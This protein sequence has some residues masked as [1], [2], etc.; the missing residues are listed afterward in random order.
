MVNKKNVIQHQV[1]LIFGASKWKH[2]FLIDFLKPYSRVVF[3][4]TRDAYPLSPLEKSIKVLVWAAKYSSD[5]KEHVKSLNYPVY[6]LEDGFLRSVGLGINHA[7]PL[8]LVIDSRGM[9]YD[10]SKESDLEHILN[11]EEFDSPALERAEQ[12]IKQ[13]VVLKLTKYNLKGNEN[14]S[15]QAWLDF[16][17]VAKAQ[18]KRVVLVP[19]QVDSDA[20][21]EKGSPQTKTNLALLQAVATKYP[22]AFIVYKPHPDVLTQLRPGN[23][24]QAKSL[25]DLQVTNVDMADLLEV[26]DEV[27]TMTSLTGFEAL[28]RHKKVVC[29]GLPFY[30]GWG[31][32]D[33]VLSCDR[34]QR[35]LSLEELVIGA[36]IKYPTYCDP[37]TGHLIDVETA[38]ELLAQQKSKG[39]LKLPYHRRLYR[40]F[41][42]KLLMPL[43][44]VE[45]R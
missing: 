31:L 10:C 37:K 41:R 12:L 40:W 16:I 38:V 34:I 20:S 3:M 2:A 23:L 7:R 24:H 9:Y 36:L 5:V 22:D 1:W 28:L 6:L 45:K 29:Y 35:K 14:K 19:G 15:N 4:H 26:V 8:S 33:D 11:F 30:A 32:T 39:E 21:I 42:L 18:G 27:H 43:G 13:L 17:A 44:F 25:F